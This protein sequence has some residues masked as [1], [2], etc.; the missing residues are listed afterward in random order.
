MSWAAIVPV[1]LEK[2]IEAGMDYYK[3]QPEQKQLAVE[4]SGAR[5]T[6][7]TKVTGDKDQV[8]KD[9]TEALQLVDGLEIEE[10]KLDA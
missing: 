8:L 3:E 7:T 1:V 2:L 5:V 6:I 4:T 9:I 10:V